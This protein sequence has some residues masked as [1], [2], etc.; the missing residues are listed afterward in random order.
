[1]DDI[2]WKILELL[3]DDA[4]IPVK[5]MATMLE[6]GGK[7]ISDR[8]KKLK[9]RKII[10]GF[11]TSVNWKKAGKRMASAII[12]VKVTPQERS[13]FSAI[14][15]EIS[16]D[17]R[18]KDV[19]VVTGEYDLIIFVEGGDMEDLSNFVTEKLA[20]KRDVTGT[21]THMVLEEYKRDGVECFDEE[22]KRLKVSL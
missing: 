14:C 3:G 4:R 6:L 13:G 18:V 8:V 15:K 11:K 12:Q 9:K 1:M 16:K 20:P 5:D 22:N 7:E 10:R 2:D 17:H 21:Y 19:L